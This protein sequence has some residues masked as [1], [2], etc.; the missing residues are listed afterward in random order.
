M[1]HQRSIV[2]EFLSLLYLLKKHKINMENIFFLF[3]LFV[4]VHHQLAK[5][6]QPA[7]IF[8]PRKYFKPAS[9]IF[10]RYSPSDFIQIF[11]LR[12]SSSFSFLKYKKKKKKKQSANE[13]S[14]FLL[15]RWE[16]L[17]DDSFVPVMFR[18]SECGWSEPS[19]STFNGKKGKTYPI[20]Q[21]S[22]KESRMSLSN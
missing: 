13:W 19:A 16:S 11:I 12:N 20:P 2:W 5:C 14:F 18:S 4:F 17:F 10:Y 3:C 7:T 21:S 1:N 6:W 9:T 15:F 8:K 22:N